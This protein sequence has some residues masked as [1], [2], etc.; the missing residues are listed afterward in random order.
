MVDGAKVLRRRMG[1]AA[2]RVST[3]VPPNCLVRLAARR[4]QA[5]R[6]MVPLLGLNLNAPVI[7]HGLL[8]HEAV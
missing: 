2:S 6:G 4:D 8:R 5:L 3:R 7:R 1:A